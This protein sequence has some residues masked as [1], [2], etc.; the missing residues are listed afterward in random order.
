MD[1]AVLGARARVTVAARLRL[2]R[3]ALR[4]STACTCRATGSRSAERSASGTRRSSSSCAIRASSSSSSCGSL[5][6]AI[7][8]GGSGSSAGRASTECASGL[9]SAAIG[10]A[11]GPIGSSRE[12]CRAVAPWS[13][14]GSWSP[15]ARTLAR[16]RLHAELTR[17]RP[18][19]TNPAH[20]RPEHL[21]PQTVEQGRTG[22]L[23]ARTRK[24]RRRRSPPST[25]ESS[26][27][28]SR[29]KRSRPRAVCPSGSTSSSRSRSCCSQPPPYRC[30]QRPAPA[31]L[32]FWLVTAERLRSQARPRWSR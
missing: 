16:S 4:R 14:P 32:P 3:D 15:G 31:R 24:P 12:R 1:P 5:P 9:G 23:R 25:R 27:H 10:F 7:A 17:A 18:R 30:V 21:A 13:M 2:S 8:S 26:A 28:T 11:R 22:G 20:R 29:G 19:P 6:T